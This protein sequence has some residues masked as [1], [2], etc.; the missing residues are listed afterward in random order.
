MERKKARE[1]KK[2]KKEEELR[3]K[4]ELQAKKREERE[5][6]KREA[7]GKR[8]RR[9]EAEERILKD[10]EVSSDDEVKVEAGKCFACELEYDNFIE[11]NNCLK[12]FHPA[13]ADLEN[14]IR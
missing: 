3:A 6:K 13:C 7:I 4:R 10:I 1:E 14:D 11:C 2:L 12:R 5:K 9:Q 8:K